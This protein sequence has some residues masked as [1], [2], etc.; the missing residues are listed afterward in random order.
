MAPLSDKKFDIQLG[1]ML[2]AAER[3]RH[4]LDLKKIKSLTEALHRTEEDLATSSKVIEELRA[5]LK[6]EHENALK[7]LMEQQER[8]LLEL[9]RQLKDLQ[10]EEQKHI[11][12]ME[13]QLASEKQQLAS[14]HA[15]LDT[16]KRSLESCSDERATL[17]TELA[18]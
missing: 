18:S 4:G 10:G 16:V 5:L 11:E 6:D 7:Q 2:G 12:E 13:G 14:A 17:K 15:E 3:V 9:Q 8:D 1:R